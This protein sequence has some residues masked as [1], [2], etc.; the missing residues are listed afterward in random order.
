LELGPKVEQG[1]GPLLGN[2]RTTLDCTS[3]PAQSERDLS[4]VIEVYSA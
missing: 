3:G 2:S 4:F 1:E